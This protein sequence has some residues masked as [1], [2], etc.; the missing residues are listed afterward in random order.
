MPSGLI[1]DIQRYS[2]DDGPGIRTTVFLKGCPLRCRWCQ[3]PESLRA[4][5]EIGFRVE[6][7][8]GC[9]T[10]LRACPRDAVKDE[11][12]PRT[13]LSRCNICG[14]CAETCP[15]TA[16]F[17]I[18]RYY[19][20]AELLEEILRDSV[21]YDESAGGVTLSG[22][23]PTQQ[24]EFT[25]AFLEACRKEGLDTAIETNGFV[26]LERLKALLPLLDHIYFDLKII[27][28][29]SHNRLTGVKN[30]SI[31]ENARWLAEQGAPVTFRM[32]V[33]PGMTATQ[34]NVGAIGRLLNEL[35]VYEVQLCPYQNSWI[36]KLSWLHPNPKS[37]REFPRIAP[38]GD[39]LVSLVKD[40][41]LRHGVFARVTGRT[42]ADFQKT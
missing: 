2:L 37:A 15:T 24:F 27:D 41:F 28:H 33:V 13:D 19:S 29:D 7:C 39:R 21:F 35:E 20:V 30:K 11:G 26:A 34:A 32:P 22:G 40:E 23:E 12:S 18:G 6:R 16:L 36:S 17:L 9:K 8:I 31:L 14:K 3:N 10:C 42:P 38:P 4:E 1:F 5:P 25:R